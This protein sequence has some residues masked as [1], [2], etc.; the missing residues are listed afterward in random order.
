MND[1]DREIL[2][3]I[4]RVQT[5]AYFAGKENPA[6][7]IDFQTNFDVGKIFLNL[8]VGDICDL[9]ITANFK[10]TEK[11]RK[12]LNDMINF[13]LRFNGIKELEDRH[14]G[15]LVFYKPESE[16]GRIKQFDNDRQIAFVVY[17]G[18]VRDRRILLD[19]YVAKATNYKDLI[20]EL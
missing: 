11:L 19:P 8:Q 17:G 15:A 3:L 7:V 10:D 6:Y 12:T 5:L 14:L 4:F 9:D 16:Y 20:L 1:V 13:L 18:V 2:N